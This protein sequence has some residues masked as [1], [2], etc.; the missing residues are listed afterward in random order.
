MSFTFLLFLLASV[1]FGFT[2]ITGNSCVRC[3]VSG[4]EYIILENDQSVCA[5]SADDFEE[6]RFYI[7]H[8]SGCRLIAETGKCHC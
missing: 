7:D 2:C 8:E 5:K 1:P 3:I 6:A 4:C